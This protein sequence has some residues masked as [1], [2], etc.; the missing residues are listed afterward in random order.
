MRHL[1]ILLTLITLAPVVR[2]QSGSY[3]WM[4][5]WEYEQQQKRE[6]EAHDKWLWVPTHL[7][8]LPPQEPL[9][10][11]EEPPNYQIQ[12]QQEE[13]RQVETEPVLQSMQNRSN[14]QRQQWSNSF[15]RGFE[16][17]QQAHSSEYN[18]QTSTNSIDYDIVPNQ[19][20]LGPLTYDLKPGFVEVRLADGSTYTTT[21]ACAKALGW[22]ILR[23][24]PSISELRGSDLIP[25][26]NGAFLG[27][28]S[29]EWAYAALGAIFVTILIGGIASGQFH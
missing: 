16:M 14:A 19:I 21:Y 22:T 13:Q 5:Q 18:T 8:T 27:L 9:P 15:Q 25:S 12:P 6:Q 4:Q 23:H 29:D 24:G 2:A 3:D 26:N 17:G 7:P 10:Q 28:T 11:L 1:I 20:H